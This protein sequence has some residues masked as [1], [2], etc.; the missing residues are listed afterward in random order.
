[1]PG[2]LLVSTEALAAR[3]RGA[4]GDVVS[5][6]RAYCDLSVPSLHDE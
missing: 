6:T 3:W 4:H 2:R 5:L 1:M